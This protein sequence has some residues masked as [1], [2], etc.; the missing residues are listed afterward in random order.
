MLCLRFCLLYMYRG[1]YD[2]LRHEWRVPPK[3]QA[4][5][6]HEAAPNGLSFDRSAAGFSH[7][8]RVP[9][10]AS[11]GVYDPIRGEWKVQP[12]N[13]RVMAGLEFAP[14]KVFD[15]NNNNSLLVSHTFRHRHRASLRRK[16]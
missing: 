13:G 16:L 7:T 9:L 4:S 14:R 1:T 8:K 5:A 6:Q 15:N 3:S 2:V 11:Q 10:P 12:R